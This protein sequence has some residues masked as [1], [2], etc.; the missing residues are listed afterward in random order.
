[1]NGGRRRFLGATAGFGVG[2]TLGRESSA[3]QAHGWAPLGPSG[4]PAL[5][6]AVSNA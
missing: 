2:V 4:G 1:M 3:Q 6:A 5:A